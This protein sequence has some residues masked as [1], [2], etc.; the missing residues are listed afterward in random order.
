M[1][2]KIIFTCAFIFVFSFAAA[3]QKQADAGVFGLM[4][5]GE[6]FILPECPTYPSGGYKITVETICWKNIRAAADY[7]TQKKKKKKKDEPAAAAPQALTDTVYVAFPFSEQPLLVNGSSVVASVIDGVLESIGFNTAGVDN[8][9]F[10]LS[11]LKEKYG[12]PTVNNP[13][14]VQNHL[15]A[16]FES[17]E[18]LWKFD[19]LIVRFNSTENSLDSGLVNIDSPKGVKHREDALDAIFKKNRSL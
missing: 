5:I 13:L 2:Q 18:A 12:K 4:K 11:K 15:G 7:S 9:E 8:Q 10:V 16:T 14:K 17:V 1:F 3:A 19:N 6:K